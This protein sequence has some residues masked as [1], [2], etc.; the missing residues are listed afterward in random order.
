MRSHYCGLVTEALMG[1]TVTLCGWVNR[2]RDHG[3]VIFVDVRDREGYVQ[4]VCDPDRA[5]MF[6]TAEGL[7]N[8]LGQTVFVENR[9]GAGGNIG[10]QYVEQSAADG[11]TILLAA[12][13][14]FTI[15]Q[16]LYKDLAFDP[17]KKF[18]AITVLVD[19]PSV[20]FIPATI[21][22]NGFREFVNYAKANQGKINYGSPGSGTTPHISAESINKSFGLGMTHIPYKGASQAVAALLAGDIQFYL[23][24]AGLGAPHVKSGK[25]RA[26]AVSSKS[27]LDIFPDIPT[28]NEAGLG[29]IN[30]SNWWGVA[31]PAGTPGPISFRN[32][33]ARGFKAPVR[34]RAGADDELLPLEQALAGS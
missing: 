22:V 33:K 8:E 6:K 10:T 29:G 11:Y 1:Q 17:I 27:R 9:P 19:V 13:N 2:R 20:I 12:T 24:G 34:T 28:F 31:V 32:V 25:L 15:N 21:P 23:A 14:N 26:I 7:R 5:D 4:V 16:F 30:A 3:G 18:D